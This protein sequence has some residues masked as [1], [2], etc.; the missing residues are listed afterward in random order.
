MDSF[1]NSKS[2]T[3][4]NTSVI[5][6][7]QRLL[8]LFS[9]F[10]GWQLATTFGSEDVS[11]LIVLFVIIAF[12]FISD[13]NNAY[14]T[15]RG[16]H[17]LVNIY[18]VGVNFSL[19][20]IL[21]GT[22]F[23]FFYDIK[24]KLVSFSLVWFF[25][26]LLLFLTSAIFIRLLFLFL[27]KKG[28]RIKKVGIFGESESAYRLSQHFNSYPWLGFS[29]HGFYNNSGTEHIGDNLINRLG[30]EDN[31]FADVQIGL[32][33]HVYI[34]TDYYNDEELKR[35]LSKLSNTT[36]SVNYIP[37]AI[38]YG[39]L[40]AV[41]TE[42]EGVSIISVYDTSFNGVNMLTK[43]CFDVFASMLLIIFFSPLMVLIALSV[44]ATSPGPILFKQKRYGLEGKEINVLK[45]RTMHCS[46]D[47]TNFRQATPDD[48]RVTVIGRVLRK[49]SLDELPQLFNVFYGSMSLV[50][51]RPH[52]IAHNEEFRKL[53]HGYMLRH[54]VKPG[55]TGW[56]QICGWRGETDT[57]EKMTKRIEY[58][59]FYINNWT[60][61]LDIKILIMTISR[62]FLNKNAY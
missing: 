18:R 61:M 14:T 48:R 56:A 45:F 39:L 24:P 35:I 28:M 50:G 37:N 11:L 53:I 22:C 12:Q 52:A 58:D 26:S 31:L 3:K 57:L 47:D 55:I 23:Y 15:W 20:L 38:S 25:T 41:N 42:I 51:P 16:E 13:V 6:V 54:K 29:L 7:F 46:S 5:S 36:C 49:T 30:N 44:M 62:G 17:L 43:R 8:D 2:K 10:L 9:V 60:L 21:C 4:T 59:L 34:A 19:A 33:N 40:R 1:S 32:V 27:R